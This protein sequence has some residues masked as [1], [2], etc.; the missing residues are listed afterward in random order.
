LQH[1][2]SHERKAGSVLPS[3]LLDTFTSMWMTR[4]WTD[5]ELR[6]LDEAC[7][8][9]FPVPEGV[10]ELVQLLD[11]VA[12]LEVTGDEPERVRRRRHD[13]ES[14][15]ARA[16]AEALLESASRALEMSLSD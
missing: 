3:G 2:Y 7:G 1:E 16:G 14:A 15:S 13:D 10:P 4:G 8:A 11:R 9:E 5:L 12:R 6:E